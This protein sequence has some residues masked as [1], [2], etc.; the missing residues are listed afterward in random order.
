MADRPDGERD[1]LR[2][3]LGT[4]I[5]SVYSFNKKDYIKG[6]TLKRVIYNLEH[7]LVR[8]RQYSEHI[9]GI[10]AGSIIPFLFVAMFLVK[11]FYVDPLKN[12]VGSSKDEELMIIVMSAAIIIMIFFVLVTRMKDYTFTK[13]GLEV[14]SHIN[15]LKAFL[16]LS[17]KDH[18]TFVQGPE[19]VLGASIMDVNNETELYESLL[20]YAILFSLYKNWNDTLKEVDYDAWRAWF[21]GE[22]ELNKDMS[23]FIWGLDSAIKQNLFRS[24]LLTG[25]VNRNVVAGTGGMPGGSGRGG[26][27]RIGGR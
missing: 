14:K 15:S 5:G 16:G 23:T 22:R 17:K 8:R 18:S 27:G 3:L 1:F 13:K 26:G 9:Y 4:K 7:K 6:K 25:G 2:V 12:I 11:K 20:P 24:R 19:E 21:N 10:I